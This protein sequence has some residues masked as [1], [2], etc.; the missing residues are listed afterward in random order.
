MNVRTDTVENLVITVLPDNGDHPVKTALVVPILPV[1]IM[2]PA[3]MMA[4]V[5]ARMDLMVMRV[6]CVRRIVGELNASLVSGV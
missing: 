3:E 4:D 2:V 6:S 1:I 5:L